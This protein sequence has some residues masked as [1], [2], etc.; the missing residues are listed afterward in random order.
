MTDIVERLRDHERKSI[1][2]VSIFGQAADEIERLR[3]E[4]EQLS[5]NACDEVIAL[6]SENN[7]MRNEIAERIGVVAANAVLIEREACAEVCDEHA[8]MHEENSVLAVPDGDEE[9]RQR[10]LVYAKHIRRVGKS[11]R[12]RGEGK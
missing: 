11:I 5:D 4:L 12:E 3:A 6:R 1:L 8:A 10:F 2:G 7:A 9:L